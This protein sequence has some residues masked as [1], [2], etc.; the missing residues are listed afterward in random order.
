MGTLARWWLFKYVASPEG[1][2]LHADD[3]AVNVNVWLTPDSAHRSGGGLEVFRRR[4]SRGKKFADFNQVLPEPEACAR[5]LELRAGGVDHVPY[6]Q[7]RA[8]IFESDRFHQ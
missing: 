8:V 1:V 7:N 6:R 4:P 2:G 3:G 5:E